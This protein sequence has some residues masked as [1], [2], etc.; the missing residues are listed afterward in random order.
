MVKEIVKSQLSTWIRNHRAFLKKQTL[1]RDSTGKPKDSSFASMIQTSTLVSTESDIASALKELE[2]KLVENST[3]HVKQL[4]KITMS[5]RRL[6]IEKESSG[7]I[8]IVTKY[9]SLQYYQPISQIYVLDHYKFNC[10][11]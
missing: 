4:L 10:L 7:I 1:K 9:P 2:K 3:S 8:E 11:Q 6:W 5:V